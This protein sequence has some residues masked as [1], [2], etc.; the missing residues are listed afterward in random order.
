MG[1]SEGTSLFSDIITVLKPVI[2]SR[3]N[4]KN[5]YKKLIK[6]FDK[7]DWDGGQECL[8]LDKAYDDALKELHKDW[9]EDDEDGD[10]G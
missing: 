3:I 9:F 2:P 1:W 7:T 10:D 6:V 5:V 4:R 8:G